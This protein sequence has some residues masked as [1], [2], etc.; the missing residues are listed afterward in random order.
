MMTEYSERTNDG[1]D[2]MKDLLSNHESIIDFLCGIAIQK[3]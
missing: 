3:G 1:L 2:F